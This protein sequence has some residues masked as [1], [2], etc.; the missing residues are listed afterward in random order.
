MIQHG[1]GNFEILLNNEKKLENIKPIMNGTIK[2]PYENTKIL[3]DN[4]ER[5]IK[6]EISDEEF[7]KNLENLGYRLQ[8]EFINVEGVAFS[9][10][11]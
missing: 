7:Y 5:K 8:G 3:I 1:S 4:T 2:V 10:T 6:F 9:E 11:G